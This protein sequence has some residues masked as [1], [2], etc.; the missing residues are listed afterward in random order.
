MLQFNVLVGNVE[1]GCL[2]L[3]FVS[4]QRKPVKYFCLTGTV[5]VLSQPNKHCFFVMKIVYH[6]E[7]N[8]ILY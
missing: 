7:I 4:F 2:R 1:Y 5:V 6:R 3:F 8:L